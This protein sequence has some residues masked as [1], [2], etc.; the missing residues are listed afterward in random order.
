MDMNSEPNLPTNPEFKLLLELTQ[1]APCISQES[2][3]SKLEHHSFDRNYFLDAM[4][5]HRITPQVYLQ[6]K[7]LKNK[8]P[9]DFFSRL[10]QINDQCRTLSLTLSL[11]LVELT[12]DLQHQHID[13]ILLKGEVLSQLFYSE[14]NYREFRD[15]DILVDEKNIDATEQILL[16]SGFIRNMPYPEASPRQLSYFNQHK[17][18]REY[19]HP[20]DGTIV[21]LHWRLIEVDHP[22]NDHVS[23]VLDSKRATKIHGKSITCMESDDLWLYLC[24]HGSL[25]SWYRLRWINDIALLLD[26]YPPENWEQLLTLANQYGCKKS[27]IEAVGLACMLFELEMPET[28]QML[29]KKN[30]TIQRSIAFSG[31]RLFYQRST[32]GD[33]ITYSRRIFFCSPPGSLLKYLFNRVVISSSDFE[34]FPLPDRLF[35]AYYLMRPFFFLYRHILLRKFDPK[36]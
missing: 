32:C 34:T 28:I 25:S 14:R 1:P 10:K 30:I 17:K 13:F 9:E 35:F 3:L 31:K 5:W 27:V 16:A 29:I 20:D 12:E 4:A 8:L 21:E 6:L 7:P 33:I 22:F 19:Y 11:R 18:D 2:I 36:T 24:L 15:I 26:L 23:K